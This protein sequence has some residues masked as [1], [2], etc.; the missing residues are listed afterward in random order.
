MKKIV[1]IFFTIIILILSLRSFIIIR[2]HG[3]DYWSHYFDKDYLAFKGM[4]NDDT[5][6]LLRAIKLGEKTTWAYCTLAN[7]YVKEKNNDLAKI[8]YKKAINKLDLESFE[9]LDRNYYDYIKDKNNVYYQC[10]EI[11]DGDAE[12]FKIIATNSYYSKDKN[13]IFYENKQ[14][15]GI[16]PETFTLLG[17]F[18]YGKDKN[19]VYYRDKLI[20]D[21]D[22]QTF[23]DYEQWQETEDNINY[24]AED[25]YNYYSNGDIVKV[26]Y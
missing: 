14:L 23:K 11:K 10:S 22:S 12:S 16:D 1:F 8:Y 26:K 3:Y 7:I 17:F 9:V 2:E 6:Y 18:N 15:K 21:A 25:K 20:K 13:N 4:K 5:E 19:S 24:N